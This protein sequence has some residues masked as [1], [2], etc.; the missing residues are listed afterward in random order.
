MA[1]PMVAIAS[2]IHACRG[3]A[4][5]AGATPFADPAVSAACAEVIPE[6]AL[7]TGSGPVGS[8]ERAVI[9]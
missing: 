5:S 8:L 7:V 9:P 6:L 4:V 3:T 1:N 2:M